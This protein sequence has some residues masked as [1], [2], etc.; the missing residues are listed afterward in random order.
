MIEYLGLW[1]LIALAI[2]M[3]VLISVVGAN[4]RLTTRALWGVI[5]LVPVIGFFAWFLLGPRG[6]AA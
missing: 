6:R 5:L 3:W 1:V 4:A 2:N